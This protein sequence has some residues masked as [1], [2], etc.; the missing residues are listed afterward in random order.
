MC[1]K[2]IYESVVDVSRGK[3]DWMGLPFKIP[4]LTNHLILGDPEAAT[5]GGGRNPILKGRG[6][7]VGNFEKN[8]K[9]TP[10]YCF[11]GVPKL[12]F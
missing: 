1:R 10:R 7:L 2:R 3:G 12:L 9:E 11:V 6:L 8:P 5:R 4:K